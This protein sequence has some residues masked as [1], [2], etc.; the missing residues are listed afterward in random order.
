MRTRVITSV[1]LVFGLLMPALPTAAQAATAKLGA[2]CTKAGATAKAGSV[3][4]VCKKSKGKLV[5]QKYVETAE[6][7]QAKAQYTLQL[8]SYQDIIAKIT[9]ARAATTGLTGADADA[10]RKQI[11][12]TEESV[13]PLKSLVDQLAALTT[14]ICKL[15]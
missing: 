9:E 13:K 11:D 1:L 8:K 6:C 2:K 14:Q 12:A 15:G 5:W 3:T 10:L 7:K 4:L